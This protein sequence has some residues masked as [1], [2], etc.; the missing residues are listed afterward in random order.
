[1]LPGAPRLRGE[2]SDVAGN[3]LSALS[4]HQS[5]LGFSPVSKIALIV[6]DGLGTINL[7]DNSGHARR[8]VSQ[9]SDHGF[10][11]FSGLPSTTS[12]A[13]AS[14]T[15]GV[16][17]GRHGMMG[18]STRNPISG[19]L[20][21]HLKPF[22]EGIE[23]EVW[24]PEPTIFETLAKQSI[25]T[26]AIGEERFQGTDFSRAILRGA[27]FAG[28]HKLADHSALMRSFFDT[29]ETGLCYLYWPVLDRVGHA[30]GVNSADWVNEL[31]KLD[32][33]VGELSDALRDDEA[34]LMV[35]DHGMV[36]VSGADRVVLEASHP[37]RSDIALV[38]GEPRCLHL[39]AAHEAPVGFVDRVRDW[40]GNRGEVL[41]RSDCVARNI[42]G[43]VTD[44]HRLRIGDAVIFATGSWVFYDEATASSASY[45]MVGQHGSSSA[46][47]TT[48]PCIAFGAWAG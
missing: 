42:F 8:L 35:A 29:H 11:L 10:S 32:A 30:R 23:P 46:V 47:E 34:A 12:S 41:S 3:L 39:Y 1:M 15:T 9:L 31:E 37:L 25:P 27:E 18:Y 13:L 33:W 14:L 21:N 26:L 45:Q 6:V 2:I 22:P 20:L 38:G 19:G 16:S 28:S 44:A 24:Q 40:V 7:T 36:S 48:V 17:S 5:A 43:E 4:G